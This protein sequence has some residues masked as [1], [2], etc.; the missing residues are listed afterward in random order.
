MNIF[1]NF[2]GQVGDTMCAE[3]F[4]CNLTLSTAII[5]QFNEQVTSAE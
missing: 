4:H 5:T 3:I 1:S 2:L